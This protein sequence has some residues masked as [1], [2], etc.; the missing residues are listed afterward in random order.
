[1]STIVAWVD[2]LGFARLFDSYPDRAAQLWRDLQQLVESCLGSGTVSDVDVYGINDGFFVKANDGK[3]LIRGLVKLYQDWFEKQTS[4]PIGLPLLR[5]ALSEASQDRVSSSGCIRSWLEG[6]G[7]RSA[8]DTE[9]VLRGGRLFCSVGVGQ[10]AR[11]DGVHL[12]EWEE[13]SAWDLPE[14]KK[15]LKLAEVL[16]PAL[17]E[18]HDLLRRAN[19]TKDLYEKALE[20]YLKAEPTQEKSKAA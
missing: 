6:P 19:T 17:A 9:A 13:L 3:R 18:G 12:Y 20:E 11:L 16:W 14:S 4:T 10:I 2:I 7:F 15:C 8:Y 1:M 5:G